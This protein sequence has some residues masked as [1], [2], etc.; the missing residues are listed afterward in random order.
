MSND[1]YSDFRAGM[2]RKDSDPKISGLR[3]TPQNNRKDW[4]GW[5]N[6][7]SP[8]KKKIVEQVLPVARPS[9]LQD[10]L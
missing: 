6:P 5:D 7:S 9:Q 3:R 8:S 4:S 10:Q 2:A 1:R